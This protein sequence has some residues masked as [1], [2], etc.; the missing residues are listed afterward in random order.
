MRLSTGFFLYHL[1]VIKAKLGIYEK[2][3]K[4]K[5]KSAGNDLA[6]NN[7]SNPTTHPQYRKVFISLQTVRAIA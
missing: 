2:K 3:K 1:F 6:R 5:S 7:K 4:V